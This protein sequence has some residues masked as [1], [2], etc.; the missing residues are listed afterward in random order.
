MA[1]V[2]Y[3]MADQTP[4]PLA[5]RD[6]FVVVG[7]E[8][9]TSNAREM[10]SDGVIPKLWQQLMG[11]NLLAKIPNRT[12]NEVIA[13]YTDYQSDKDGAYTYLLGARVS[14]ADAMP[15][16]MKARTV[17][18]GDYAV[19]EKHGNLANDAVVGLWKQVWALENEHQ[20]A[21]AYRTDYEVHHFAQ[22]GETAVELCIGVK[23]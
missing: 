8:A 16:G 10:T 18:A 12:G 19:F 5:H 20:L 7:L 1:A 6:S 14:A 22:T 21:R 17:P 11:K 9:R 3:L 2:S 4:P 15:D 23:H 13:L